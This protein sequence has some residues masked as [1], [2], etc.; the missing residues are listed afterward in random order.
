MLVLTRK[1]GEAIQIGDHIRIAL[2]EVD[3]GNVKIGIEAPRSV[4]VYREEIYRRII[5]ENRSAVH[6]GGMDMG[7][8]AEMLRRG[9]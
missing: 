9:Q 2:I 6:V 5:E 7:A 3:G 4:A 8:L 1:A